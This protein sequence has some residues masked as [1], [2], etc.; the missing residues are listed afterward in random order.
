[1]ATVNSQDMLLTKKAAN[2]ACT[3]EVGVCAIYRHFAKRG[4]EFFLL[5]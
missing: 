3:D 1:M 2:T 4:F 5:L